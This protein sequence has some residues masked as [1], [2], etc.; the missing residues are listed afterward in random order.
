MLT[1][2]SD[3]FFSIC[4]E[5]T[6]PT[7]YSLSQVEVACFIFQGWIK[8]RWFGHMLIIWYILFLKTIGL[9]VCIAIIFELYSCERSTIEVST[10]K[11]A[12]LFNSPGSLVVMFS[13]W[14]NSDEQFFNCIRRCQVVS[15][16]GDRVLIAW[17]DRRPD[18]C[19][20]WW[21][22]YVIS[23][24]SDLW[25]AA[26]GIELC[27]TYCV[28]PSQQFVPLLSSTYGNRLGYAFFQRTIN[29]WSRLPATIIYID[30]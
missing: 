4:T 24:L 13:A 22:N 20:E 6:F 16:I 21:V 7:T 26:N 12:T 10:Y 14:T 30:T 2:D 18:G 17:N 23:R 29:E 9:Y 27:A 19:V 11:R 1:E 3:T 28:D 8:Y 15:L 25:T 5:S